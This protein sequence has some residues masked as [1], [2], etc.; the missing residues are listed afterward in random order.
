MARGGLRYTSRRTTTIVVAITVMVVVGVF[1]YFQYANP[2]GPNNNLAYDWRLKLIFHDNRYP[3]ANYSLPAYIGTTSRVY[4]NH[5]LDAL[6]PPGYAAVST[7]DYTSTI[8]IQSRQDAVYTFG[9]FFNVWGQLFN[10]TCVSTDISGVGTYCTA[11]AEAM[12]YDKNNNGLYESGDSLLNVTSEEQIHVPPIGVALSSDAHIQFYNNT[13]TVYHDGDTVVY[14][15]NLSGKY[16]PAIDLLIVKGSS[17]PSAGATLQTDSRLKFFDYN[18][19]GFWDRSVPPPVLYDVGLDSVRCLN[20]G[21][22]LANG[23]TWILYL[24]SNLAAG[25]CIPTGL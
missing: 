2:Y 16:D 9:D 10:E 17:T 20:R 14:D 24:W 6:G 23:K 5:T 8:W 25:S 19:N 3:S 11:P 21:Y 1:A 7:R 13:N 12:V 22:G 15:T 18:G 4:T